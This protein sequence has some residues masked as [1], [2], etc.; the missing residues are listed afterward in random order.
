MSLFAS[1]NVA[2]GVTL[3][4]GDLAHQCP[5]WCNIN[6]R[7]WLQVPVS[8]NVRLTLICVIYLSEEVAWC[9]DVGNYCF[10]VLEIELKQTT[11]IPVVAITIIIIIVAVGDGRIPLVIELVG[12]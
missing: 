1:I 12:Y 10:V 4:A 7:L 3:L 2:V 8:S 6:T 9:D 5:V 11:M